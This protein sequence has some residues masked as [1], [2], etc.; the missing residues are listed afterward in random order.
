MV[1]Q[2]GRNDGEEINAF[3]RTRIVLKKDQATVIFLDELVPLFAHWIATLVH[4]SY[5]M[6]YRLALKTDRYSALQGN[7]KF[8]RFFSSV[9]QVYYKDIYEWNK[10]KALDR[11]P[12]FVERMNVERDCR[13][14]SFT[15]DQ[16]ARRWA[17]IAIKATKEEG[18]RWVSESEFHEF[19]QFV[20]PADALRESCAIS[21]PVERDDASS[22]ERTSG[23][24]PV[25]IE[26][27]NKNPAKVFNPDLFLKP[28][29][30]EGAHLNTLGRFLFDKLL[31]ECINA[32]IRETET[33]LDF[34]NSENC[35]DEDSKFLFRKLYFRVMQQ[36]KID[37]KDLWRKHEE[38][39]EGL[40]PVQR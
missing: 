24:S 38:S 14:E 9:L 23:S 4:Q 39:L 16:D 18:C 21:A 20:L 7:P 33:T 31:H 34:L 36:A 1:E 22:P 11:Q 32:Y 29:E 8:D 5:L 40:E 13:E 37:E 28:Q 3:T 19:L 35:L 30:K 10:Q 6:A 12:A 26:H 17:S 27:V 25:S 15:N 2:I